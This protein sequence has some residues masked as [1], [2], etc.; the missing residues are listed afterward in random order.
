MSN[1][2]TIIAILAAAL[3][4]S[5]AACGFMMVNRDSN[6][7]NEAV[8]LSAVQDDTVVVAEQQIVS[9]EQIVKETTAAAPIVMKQQV[10]SGIKLLNEVCPGD[11]TEYPVIINKLDVYDTN[12]YRDLTANVHITG[13]ANA[14]KAIAERHDVVQYPQHSSKYVYFMESGDKAGDTWTLVRMV[15]EGQTRIASV[16]SETFRP[17]S[18]APS[19]FWT[20]E[21][22][23]FV[24]VHALSDITLLNNLRTEL[25]QKQ[26][27]LSSTNYQFQKYVDG[28]LSEE[29]YAPIKAERVQLYA[30]ID[31]LQA[32]IAELLK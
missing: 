2:N 16:S 23:Y 17:Y 18:T 29:E 30:E 8:E 25:A 28:V 7:Q 15:A 31:Q 14:E 19:N 5:V 24:K 6:N 27:A 21:N 26:S 4:I 9:T 11:P 12:E 3:M 32:D 20:I 13:R 1:K 22:G 10:V